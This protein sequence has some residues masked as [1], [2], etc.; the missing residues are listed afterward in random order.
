M[1][2]CSTLF[3]LCFDVDGRLVDSGTGRGLTFR[4][5]A[6]VG[7]LEVVDDGFVVVGDVDED[8]LV[9]VEDEEDGFAAVA[10]A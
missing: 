3:A 1:D 4:F 9:V 6:H 8:G 5:C 7:K 10:E 2:G